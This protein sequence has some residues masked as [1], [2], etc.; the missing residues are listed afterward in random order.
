[1][2]LTTRS[3]AKHPKIARIT[4]IIDRSGSMASYTSDLGCYIVPDEICQSIA[5]IYSDNQDKTTIIN[6]VTFDNQISYPIV[7]LE[8][9]ESNLPLP[10]SLRHDFTPRYTT[11]LF[12]TVIESIASQ[13][14]IPKNGEGGMDTNETNTIMIFTDGQDNKSV[15]TS[16]DLRQSI[17]LYEKHGGNIVYLAA[18]Q[19][20]M[21]TGPAIG[22]S[23]GASL[24]VGTTPA[25]LKCA[26]RSATRNMSQAINHGYSEFSARDRNDSAPI[27]PI[28]A[29]ELPKL[30]RHRAHI[31]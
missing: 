10:Q 16:E 12:D 25:L 18:N 19:D 7:N 17:S 11:K 5:D 1:M 2:P 29:S 20:A 13:K 22:M 24:T 23:I 4:Y 3:M 15:H 9:N 8:L 30:R 27:P 14:I 28:K 26:I 6:V 21:K 31:F